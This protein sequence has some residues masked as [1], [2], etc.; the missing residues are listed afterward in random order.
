MPG[1]DKEFTKST[2]YV[3]TTSG[4][5]KS[6]FQNGL[7]RHPLRKVYWLHEAGTAI[8][9]EVGERGKG[10]NKWHE[11]NASLDEL[12]CRVDAAKKPVSGLNDN[13]K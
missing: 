12:N 13:G 8:P 3:S 4:M 1:E 10:I 5:Q 2:P 7:T 11:V 9:K 6:R